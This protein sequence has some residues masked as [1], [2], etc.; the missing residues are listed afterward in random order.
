MAMLIRFG[1]S[2]KVRSKLETCR[3]AGMKVMENF[4]SGV[5]KAEYDSMEVLRCSRKGPNRWQME[6][7]EE[8]WEELDVH[9]RGPETVQ[10]QALSSPIRPSDLRVQS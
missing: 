3:K 9:D 1:D 5:T 7:N 4:V 8:F 2:E 6:F 10:T